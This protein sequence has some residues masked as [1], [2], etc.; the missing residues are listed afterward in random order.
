[1]EPESLRSGDYLRHGETGLAWAARRSVLAGCGLYD[2]CIV[3]GADHVMAH[4]LCGDWSSP[5]I[6]RL[7]GAH[8]QRRR[9]LQSWGACMYARV[10]GALGWAS[11]TALH[12]WHGDRDDRR[13]TA[14]HSEF[15][16][17][18][19][20]PERDVSIAANG[21]WEWVTNKPQMHQWAAEYFASRRE[22]G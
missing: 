20:D 4:A 3:G 7:I 2:A 13:Y 1:A 19:F 17:F 11:G 8:P 9:H 5:C 14:R 18:D 6:S 12:L 10:H 15:G 22:D 16:A 21:C